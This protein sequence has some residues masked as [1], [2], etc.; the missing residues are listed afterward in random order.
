MTRQDGVSIAREWPVYTSLAQFVALTSSWNDGPETD[1]G[2]AFL[3][4]RLTPKKPI[5]IT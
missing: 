1:N 5:F 4:D 3:H 2:I